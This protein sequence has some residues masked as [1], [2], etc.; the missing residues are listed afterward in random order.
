MTQTSEHSS[1]GSVDRVNQPIGWTE[2]GVSGFKSFAEETRIQIGALTIL[3]GTNSSGKSS[4]MQPFLLMKQTLE[5]AY[6]PGVLLLD[7]PNVSFT[8]S[9]QFITK[10]KKSGPGS[11]QVKISIDLGAMSLESVFQWSPQTGM[12]IDSQRYKEEELDIQIN[13][14]PD[15][16]PTEILQACIRFRRDAF[17]DQLKVVR[18]RCFM[19]VKSIGTS[20]EFG[21]GLFIGNLRS[22]IHVQGI[23]GNPERVYKTAAV[24]GS[25]FSGQFENYVA[26]VI[27]RFQK[28]NPKQLLKLQ[29]I[30]QKLGLTD[31]VQSQRLNDTQIELRVGRVLG[32]SNAE[33]TVNIADVGFGVSQVLPVAVALLVAQPGQLV[34]IE[35]PEIH[36]HPRAQIALAEVFA[37]AANR[38][39][40]IVVETHSELFLLGIQTLVAEDKLKP[41]SVKLHWFTRNSDGSSKVTTAELDEVGAFGDWPEDFGSTALGL[42]NRYLSATETKLWHSATDSHV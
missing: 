39:V 33:D 21:Y 41:E 16:T 26:S 27:D 14:Q 23:R 38:G 2:L 7:G 34:Y 20:Y 5:A 31:T 28:E 30:L 1:S 29:E 9:E 36:L 19:K 18:E 42:E 15:M 17:P 37:E 6:D 3:A 12:S 10:I 35:Q 8:S 32:E 4:I 25:V 40:R 22:I 11:N 24:Q 13:L